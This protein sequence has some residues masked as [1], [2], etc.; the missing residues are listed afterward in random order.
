MTVCNLLTPRLP[1]LHNQQS[2]TLHWS[3]FSP[4]GRACVS[5]CFDYSGTQY[6]KKWQR[7][8]NVNILR[9]KVA[10]LN[11]TIDSKTHNAELEIWSDGSSQAQR[12]LRVGGYWS[13]FGPP[14]GRGS[15]FWSVPEQNRPVFAVQTRTAGRLPRHIA[16]ITL[17]GN[18]QSL[19]FISECFLQNL[20]N[21]LLIP[22]LSGLV[23]SKTGVKVTDEV[24]NTKSSNV[25]ISATIATL[26]L[27]LT[28]YYVP[29]TIPHTLLT[30][31][32]LAHVIYL[33]PPCAWNVQFSQCVYQ[34]HRSTH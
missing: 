30:K 19:R 10:Y 28:T 5:D 4:W 7:C 14:R 33:T 13:G 22:L 25:V 3:S 31:H 16:I 20:R 21:E 2:L 12:N 17:F 6:I 8:T 32:C 27:P 26:Y 15:H 1:K 29:P 34:A 24:W 18:L 23:R 11:A 9:I